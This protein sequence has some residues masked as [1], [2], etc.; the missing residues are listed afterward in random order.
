MAKYKLTENGVINTET[1]E[2]IPADERNRHW[3]EYMASGEQAAPIEQPSIERVRARQLAA[4]NAGFEQ[5]ITKVREGCPPSEVATWAQQEAEARAYLANDKAPAK[6]LKKLGQARGRSVASLA[7]K[8][9]EKADAYAEASAVAI[10]RRQALEDIVTA[11]TAPAGVAD[12]VWT[13]PE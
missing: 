5:Y 8:V 6:L 12:V 2:H 11:S 10:G 1:G 7:Q 4:I 3:Q 13:D 9:V